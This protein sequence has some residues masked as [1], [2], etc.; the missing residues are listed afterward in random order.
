M[1]KS[2]PNYYHSLHEKVA[3]NLDDRQVDE[4][5]K[6]NNIEELRKEL[7]SDNATGLV[8]ETCIGTNR[9]KKYYRENK[10]SN[11]IGIDWVQ[12]NIEKAAQKINS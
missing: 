7:I 11:I 3:I 4:K 5:E 1:F 8:L 10:I 2:N 6:A 9:N 12:V